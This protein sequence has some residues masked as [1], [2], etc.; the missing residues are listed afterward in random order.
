MS[1]KVH[2]WAVLYRARCGLL[3]GATAL[4]IILCV[5]FAGDQ[6]GMSNNGDYNRVMAASDLTFGDCLPTYT[7]ADV[8]TI[9]LSHGSAFSNL[10]H[11]VFG[12]ERSYPSVHVMLVRASVVANLLL[13]KL[14][15]W[16]MSTYHI[17][18]LG[19][20]YAFLYAAGIG[21]LLSQFKLRRLWQDVAVKCTAIIILCDIG[22]V[23]Y[24]NSFY[25]EGPEHIALVW[26]AAMLVRVLTRDSPTGWD[27]LW[28]A[29]AAA[30]YGWSKFFNIPIAL[31][32]LLV[33]EG[34][35][36]FR[37]RCG[38]ALA[39]GGAALALLLA[40]WLA[41]PN[42]MYVA[43]SYNAVFYGVLRDV[44][45]DTAVRY[46]TD[47]GLP[48]ELADY[49][50][51]NYYLSGLLDS[52]E[53]RGL[54]EAAESVSKSDLIR[55]YLTHPGRLWQ[56][57]NVTALHCGM[58]RPY[59]MANYGEDYPQMT[60]SYRM[61]FWGALRDWL[62]LDTLAGNLVA[63]TIVLVALIAAF[64]KRVRPLWLVPTLLALTG[65]LAYAFIMP[66]ILNG[67]GDLAKHMFA[68]QELLDLALIAVLALA[69][70]RAGW[71][72]SGG[73]LCPMAAG[74][75]ALTLVVPPVWGQLSDLWQDSRP[76][77]GLE[78][79]AY[80]TLG[81]YEGRP[82]TWL[83]VEEKDSHLTLLCTDDSI[84]MAFDTSGCNDWRDSSVRAWLNDE[85][86]SGFTPTEQALLLEQDNSVLLSNN[87]REQSTAGDLEFSCSHIATLAD[88]GY[89]RAFRVE[90][91]DLV[92]LPDIDLIAKLA[93]SG[94][95]VGDL[96][97]WLET[98]YC[99]TDS[100]TRYVASDGHIYF[101]P[102]DTIKVLRPTVEIGTAEVLSGSGNQRDPFTIS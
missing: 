90:V 99:P 1:G 18:V 36:L 26:C 37:T 28:C 91:T 40:V 52:L 16:D 39:F 12:T 51:T 94:R 63:V 72:R 75:L 10:A 73:L 13:N 81:S 82:L 22:Y 17:A 97:C 19:V 30:M 24:F 41:V 98:P 44:D 15:G 100:L 60:F 68:Y 58:I 25:G 65:G 11:I 74:V 49:K 79:G 67:E 3:F 92:T 9:D 83:V 54:R 62:A 6:I 88:R 57:A 48:D 96:S 42:W 4:V 43:T 8:Y 5:L 7:F 85:F 89:D 78:P 69:L 80:V 86:L 55:F 102:A 45:Q 61:S 31:L 53:A 84:Q 20:M 32:I 95:N 27:A 23:A 59:Y 50:D 56:Q 76:H 35:I 87:R 29:V 101:G 38:K 46:V 77:V 2:R 14:T 33:L 34:I 93:R 70:D 21:F 47:L 66:V 71:G 64:R